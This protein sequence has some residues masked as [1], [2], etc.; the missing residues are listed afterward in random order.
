MKRT[1]GCLRIAFKGRKYR[2]SILLLLFITLVGIAASGCLDKM[3]VPVV[4]VE[5]EVGFNETTSRPVI[6]SM[7]VTPMTINALKAP[8]ESNSM[9]FSN[10]ISAFAIHNHKEIGYWGAIEYTGPGTYE[11][12]LGFPT[13][14]EMAEGDSIIVEVRIRDEA[15]N[16]TARERQYIEWK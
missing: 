12:I 14:V 10:S 6:T 15:G 5:V 8:K 13:G 9:D 2:R 11:F 16:M 4:G 1:S 3:N 7:N